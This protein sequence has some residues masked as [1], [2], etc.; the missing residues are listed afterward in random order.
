MTMHNMPKNMDCGVPCQNHQWRCQYC[1]R[2][3]RNGFGGCGQKALRRL[4]DDL[5]CDNCWWMNSS[6]T[7]VCSLVLP[8]PT[9]HHPQEQ[10]I[11]IVQCQFCIIIYVNIGYLCDWCYNRFKQILSTTSVQYI[12]LQLIKVGNKHIKKFLLARVIFSL[13][14]QFK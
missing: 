14:F 5:I 10:G 11:H 7:Q 8:F 3:Q 9:F 2:G 13:S 12:Y 6:P 4:H 1:C